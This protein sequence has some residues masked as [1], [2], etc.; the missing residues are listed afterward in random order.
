MAVEVRFD[1]ALLGKDFVSQAVTVNKA[2]ILR[3]CRATGITSPIHTDEKAARVAGYRGLVAPIAMYTSIVR[4]NLPDIKLEF[5]GTLLFGGSSIE[6]LAP[7]CAGDV[8]KATT[9]LKEVYTKTGRS[10]TMVFIV[11]E[12]SLTNE[13]GERVGVAQQSYVKRGDPKRGRSGQ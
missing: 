7:V 1:R 13:R 5:G 9:H 10:G 4:S 8:V 12:A 2:V 3:Y 6:A 11:W